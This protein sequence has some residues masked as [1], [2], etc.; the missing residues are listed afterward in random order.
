MDFRLRQATPEDAEAVVL[1]QTQAH[2]ECYPHLL[3]ADFFARRRAS[4]PERVVRR[5]T[6]LARDEPRILA[7]DGNDQLMGYADAG[8]GRE[9]D[10][11]EAL[12]LYSIYTLRRTYGTGLGAALVSAAVGSGPAY[13]W[14]LENNPRAL[15]FYRKQGFRPDGKR[16]TLPPE[17][18]ELPEVRLVRR[19]QP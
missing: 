17:W 5:R 19:A 1:M 10:A 7:F 15:A 18:E 6:F 8:P 13:L 11:P 4:I 12:E 14:V 2:E 3:S 9:D 16:N